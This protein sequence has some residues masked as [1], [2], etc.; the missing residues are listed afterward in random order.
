MAVVATVVLELGM[1]VAVAVAVA[2]AVVEVPLVAEAD[3]LVE[4]V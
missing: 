2:V 4:P 1:V 3:L